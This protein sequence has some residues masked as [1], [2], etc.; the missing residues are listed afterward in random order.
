MNKKK[1]NQIYKKDI[2]LYDV[3]TCFNLALRKLTS[4]ELISSDV[5]RPTVDEPRYSQRIRRPPFRR[6]HLGSFFVSYFTGQVKRRNTGLIFGRPTSDD[7]S[8]HLVNFLKAKLKH[9]ST[10]YS[11]MS[12]LYYFLFVIFCVSCPMSPVSLDCPFLTALLIFSNVYL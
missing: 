6:F 1:R 3:L 4:W 2:L 12:C 10:S 5:G 7:I 11:K 9:V 8:S